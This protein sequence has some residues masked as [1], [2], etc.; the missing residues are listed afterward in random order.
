MDWAN[1][2]LRS[3]RLNVFVCPSDGYNDTSNN[4][5]SS[6]ADATDADLSSTLPNDPRSGALLLNW[7]RGNYGAVQ[8]GTDTDHTV[9]GNRGE[10][11]CSLPSDLEARGDGRELWSLLRGHY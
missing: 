1:S 3:T 11:E 4:F 5:L 6:S 10:H 2:T 7:A 8:G 9:N